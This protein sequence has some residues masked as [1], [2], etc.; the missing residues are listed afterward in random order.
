MA[1][2]TS[3]IRSMK[4]K[5]GARIDPLHN[6]SR[7][8]VGWYLFNEGAGSRLADISN[9]GAHGTL[10]DMDPA[11]D[12][13]GS[14]LGG[15]LHFDGADDYVFFGS[16]A[17]DTAGLEM[18]V[19]F[20]LN[21]DSLPSNGSILGNSSAPVWKNGWG[22]TLSAAGTEMDFWVDDSSTNVARSSA[23]VTGVW[24]HWVGWWDGATVKL[25]R[26]LELQ[27]TADTFSS[28]ITNPGNFE[29]GKVGGSTTELNGTL[30]DV[31]VYNRAITD[32]E[33]RQ[34]YVTPYANI[35]TPSKYLDIAAPAERVFT[36][37]LENRTFTVL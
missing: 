4:P 9:T 3:T 15:G 20:W 19:S 16:E 24:T 32:S 30:D 31:R 33:M 12:W 36:T 25:F 8:L 10:T 18:S 27:P 29:I 34:L 23:L 28:S 13:I 2:S 7:G 26:D 6:L 37:T 14:P 22:V 21:L 35:L 1:S 17:G 5:P 11:T